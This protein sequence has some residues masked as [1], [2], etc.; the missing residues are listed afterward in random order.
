MDKI[1]IKG[2]D[3]ELYVHKSKC[4]LTTYMWVNNKVNS[5][6]AALNV[7]YGS[8]NTEFKTNNKTYKVP[9]GIAHFLEHIKFNVDENGTVYDTFD[10]IG[11]DA[12][13]FTTFKYTSYLV[14]ANQN[15]KE[16]LST[17]IKYVYNPYFTKKIVEKEKGIITEEAK[18]T[19]DDPYSE[20]YYSFLQNIFNKSHYRYYITGKEDDIKSITLENINDVYNTFYHPKN[21]F[22][23]VTGNINPYEVAKIVDDTLDD[24][25]FPEFE[26]FTN[27]FP[28]ETKKV[29]KKYEVLERSVATTKVRYGIKIPLNKF[30]KYDKVKLSLIINLIMSA[31]LGSTS[32]FKNDLIS[33][34][35]AT[36]FSTGGDIYDDYFIISIVAD[37]NYP[38]ELLKRLNEKVAN[39]ELNKKDIERKRK[40]ILATMILSFDD[41]EVV[42]MKI[43]DDLI[44]YDKVI[45]NEKE[46]LEK[47]TFKEVKDVF[48]NLDLKENTTLIVKPKK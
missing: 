26:R 11:G 7:K 19:F 48:T 2:I 15:L 35:V 24:I 21:M 38:D 37:T 30:K 16:N 40:A 43:E 13:A 3:E 17:L 44:Q 20:L 9:Y 25:K 39:L 23:C 4:G 10:K 27:I 22:L 42:A 29:N 47:L 14:F 5:F 12:N 41:I 28:K 8:V 1:I 46:I 36:Y 31:N 32:D 45:D 6:Y 33:D 34:E 18:I